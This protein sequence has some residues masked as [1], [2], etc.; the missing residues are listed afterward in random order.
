MVSK[1]T[2]PF[3]AESGLDMGTTQPHIEGVT[4]DI[5]PGLRQSEGE[6]YDCPP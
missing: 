2:F 5:S 3:F 6:A 1:M 4:G